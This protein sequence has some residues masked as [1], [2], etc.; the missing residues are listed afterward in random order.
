[1]KQQKQTQLLCFVLILCTFLSLWIIVFFKPQGVTAPKTGGDQQSHRHHTWGQHQS[2]QSLFAF[3]SVVMQKQN[4]HKGFL[5]RF[6]LSFC[7]TMLCCNSAFD[8]FVRR[9]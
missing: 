3:M 8:S 1:M 5:K 4:P 6:K 2:H 9:A 7:E